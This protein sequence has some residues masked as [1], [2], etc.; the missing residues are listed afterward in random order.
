MKLDRSDSALLFAYGVLATLGTATSCL[1]LNDGAV[2]ISAGWFG[3]AWDLYFNQI[4]ARAVSTLL[5]FAAWA[6]RSVFGLGSDTYIVLAHLLYFAAPLAL[7][8]LKRTRFEFA[9]KDARINMR[10]PDKLL[11]AVKSEAARQRMPYQRF[12]RQ[13]LE[14][15]VSARK[16][17]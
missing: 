4:P 16:G 17:R 13:A 15:A 14:S 11:S 6:A 8:A 3:N 5:A 9:A 10:L 7:S 2:L 1:L 12:I